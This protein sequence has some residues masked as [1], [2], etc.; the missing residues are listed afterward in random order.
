MLNLTENP[1][2]EDLDVSH[3]RNLRK[4]AVSNSSKLRIVANDYTELDSHTLKW[5]QVSIER[6][7]G[8]IQKEWLNTEYVSGGCFGEEL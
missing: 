5:L 8:R 1:D 3:C 4:I 2:L 6:N 7:G